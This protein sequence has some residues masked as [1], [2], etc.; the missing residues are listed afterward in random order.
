MRRPLTI[1]QSKMGLSKGHSNTLARRNQ[2][3][4]RGLRLIRFA[5][6]AVA[7][8]HLA[9]A[10]RLIGMAYRQFDQLPPATNS[11]RRNPIHFL[12][13]VGA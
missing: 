10:E 7:A 2:L 8:G 4:L 12:P 11:R 13:V 6:H 3:R 9:D 5:D 1:R